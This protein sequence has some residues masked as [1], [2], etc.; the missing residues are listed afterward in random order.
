VTQR[1]LTIALIVILFCALTAF[2]QAESVGVDIKTGD[3]WFGLYVDGVKQGSLHI[4]VEKKKGA[5]AEYYYVTGQENR[6]F[7]VKDKDVTE[8]CDY[9]ASVGLDLKPMSYDALE[10]KATT[11]NTIRARVTAGVAEITVQFGTSAA[12]PPRKV[13]LVEGDCW[14]FCAPLM[15]AARKYAPDKPHRYG[16]IV[17][18]GCAV[19][20]FNVSGETK[21]VTFQGNNTAATEWVE[22]ESQKFTLVQ[23][24]D[25][26]PLW[27]SETTKAKVTTKY[28]CEP[29]EVA[30]SPLDFDQFQKKAKE[31]GKKTRKE[32]SPLKGTRFENALDPVGADEDGKESGGF[33]RKHGAGAFSI[34]TAEG[35]K[36]KMNSTV[37]L[38]GFDMMA[39]G[40]YP[41]EEADAERGSIFC[42]TMGSRKKKDGETP[43]DVI[44]EYLEAL[45]DQEVKGALETLKFD[46]NTTITGAEIEARVIGTD[47]TA[48]YY[49]MTAFS[50]THVFF[51]WPFVVFITPELKTKL[52][53]Y[54]PD[55]YAMMGSFRITGK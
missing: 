47:E 29:E 45:R 39:Q 34:R 36:L 41:P 5:T 16:K 21:K 50:D 26:S 12:N 28:I 51:I 3:T 20:G 37:K 40:I 8:S 53:T 49:V 54:Q 19:I 10:T 23:G 11:K 27:W 14:C 15:F 24:E 55:F 38:G 52:E 17:E 32:N 33:I 30:K 35:W 48:T 9:K 2:T 4:A 25:G 44:K 43:E 31:E 7:K 22:T 1:Q 46:E 18:L 6:A 13:N 42:L